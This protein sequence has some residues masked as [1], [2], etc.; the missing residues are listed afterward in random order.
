ALHRAGSL[1][2]LLLLGVPAL[3][4]YLRGEWDSQSTLT[5]RPSLIFLLLVSLKGFLFASVMFAA[6]MHAICTDRTR[7][8]QLQRERTRQGRRSKWMNLKAVLS[9]GPSLA[10]I[11]PF[12]SPKP[13][14]APG[15]HGVA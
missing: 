9:H 3:H 2:L 4:G 11:S 7:T 5:P 12:A 8:E 15:H 10:W 1:H 14:P 13:Q 6:Q